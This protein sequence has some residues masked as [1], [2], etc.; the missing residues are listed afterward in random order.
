MIC[1]C[2]DVVIGWARD[3]YEVDENVGQ[4][5]L[6]A[7]VHEGSLAVT[8][9]PLNVAT[10]DGTASRGGPSVQQ[11]YIPIPIP[12]Q[13]FFS[14]AN[15]GPLCTDIPIVDDLLLELTIEEFFADLSFTAGDEQDRVT[16][17]PGTIEVA[18]RDNDCK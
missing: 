7:T 16:I 5:R 11:D 3:L 2:T 9:P 10:R 18:I 13:F 15:M 1:F 12:D 17:M 6:C 4:A 8:L 14:A